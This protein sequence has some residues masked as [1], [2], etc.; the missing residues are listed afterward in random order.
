MKKILFAIPQLDKGGPDRV[1]FEIL[2]GLSPR[3]F[4]LHLLTTAGAGEYWSLLP[5]HVTKHVVMRSFRLW[6]RYPADG[7]FSVIWKIKPD[8]VVTT[9]RMNSTA[10][11]IYHFL[12]K[13]TKLITR[14]TNDFSANSAEVRAMGFKQN[15]AIQLNKWLIKQADFLIAQSNYMAD[16]LTKHIDNIPQVKVLYNPISDAYLEPRLIDSDTKILPGKPSLV[17]VGR[18]MP[19]KGYDILIPAMKHVAI[20]FPEAK[21]TIYGDGPDKEKLQTMID[22]LNLNDYVTLAGFCSNPLPYVKNANLFVLSSRYEG[23]S[24]ATLEALAVG[25]P[26]VVTDCPG[27]NAEIISVGRNGYLCEKEN[28]T[29]LA[30]RIN[31]AIE[32][33]WSRKLIKDSCFLSFGSKKIIHEYSCFLKNASA[34]NQEKYTTKNGIK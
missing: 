29:D 24:N 17:S 12:P 4:D 14:I 34:N 15:F 20:D 31:A 27:A 16:D 18:L 26:V 32:N 23:F 33:K 21:L 8:V 19:Q 3:D 30:H 13:K 25:T 28:S 7:L 10:N 11:L 5:E 22:D 6:H 9:L 2:S 1:F